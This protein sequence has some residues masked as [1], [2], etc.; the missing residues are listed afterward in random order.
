MATIRRARLVD[1]NPRWAEC[2]DGTVCY[3]R[4]DCPEAHAEHEHCSHTIPFKPPLDGKP[5]PETIGDVYW[6]RKGEAFESL[7]LGP[8]IARHPTFAKN[9][10]VWDG[11]AMHVNLTDGVFEFSGDSHVK[12]NSLRWRKSKQM[13]VESRDTIARMPTNLRPYIKPAVL[14]APASWTVPDLCK[15]Y[16]WPQGLAGGGIIGIVELGGGW[17]PDDLRIFF[18]KIGQPIPGVVDVNLDLTNTPGGDAD[19]EV[20]LD[21]QVAAAAYFC[22]TG[23]RAAVRVYWTNSIAAG[24]RAATKDGCATCSI[25]WGADEAN[26]SRDEMRDVES[27]AAEAI[28]AGTIVFAASGDNDSSDGGPGPANVDMPASSPSIIGCGG[29]VKYKSRVHCLAVKQQR[30]AR[31]GEG[32]SGSGL[33][34]VWNNE[35]GQ[36]NG[37]GTG[38]GYSTVW[39]MPLWQIGAPEVV[40]GGRMV[41]DVAA[42]ADPDT[43]YEIVVGGQWQVVGGT[44]AVAPLYAGLFAAF[45]G[46]TVGGVRD[47]Q[48]GSVLWGNRACFVDITEGDNGEYKAEVG[49]DPCTGLGVPNGAAL[50][51]LFGVAPVPVDPPAPPSPPK[52]HPKPPKPPPRRPPPRRVIISDAGGNPTRAPRPFRASKAAPRQI[53]STVSPGARKPKGAILADAG[54]VPRTFRGRSPRQVRRS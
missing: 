19:G 12:P 46:L 3:L 31:G 8:S 6:E 50:A 22:A 16:Q 32:P 44:S 15:A 24:I 38:G 54:S 53:Y 17:T 1:C 23:T 42:N 9:G 33:E 37:S 11:C 21:I 18:D 52:P 34:R 40:S 48:I 4:F 20:A 13:T 45:G 5:W 14:D 29:T 43:G 30:E 49:P 36:V 2:T 35:P 39:K 7:T 51:R 41:P 25:S 27:A 10:D 26:W 28:K 47:G